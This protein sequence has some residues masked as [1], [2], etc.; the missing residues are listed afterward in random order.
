MSAYIE[1]PKTIGNDAAKYNQQALRQRNL[2]FL[3][4]YLIN[5]P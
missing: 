2:R 3:N 1:I 5:Y 4:P